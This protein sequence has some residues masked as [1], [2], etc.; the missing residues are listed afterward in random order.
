MALL[1]AMLAGFEQQ[2]VL[3]SR[4]LP[5]G[6]DLVFLALV[7]INVIGIGLL[8]FLCGRNLVKLVVERRRGVIG[9]KLNTKFVV[10]FVFAAGLSTTAMFL[11]SSFL[12]THA[13]NTWFELQVSA[14]LE[15]A[16]VVAETYY[17]EAENGAL[18]A[19]RRVARQIEERRL[20]REDALDDL[21]S[22][23]TTK[24]L[25][26]DLGVVEVFSAQLDRL[27]SATH[28]E[29]AVVSLEAPDSDFI[30]KGLGGVE[31]TVIE[32]AG[33]GELIRAIVPVRSTFQRRL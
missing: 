29:V 15:E 1:L 28:P 10:S 5:I 9:A 22:F 31:G 12:V 14:G 27:A 32:D 33:A 23:V 21:R 18:L 30:R 19:S 16:L 4:S 26:Y 17:A 20:L 8:V 25:E 24:Q 13:V 3:F 2:V 6:S 11:V 7:N